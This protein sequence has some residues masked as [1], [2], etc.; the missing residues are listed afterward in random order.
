MSLPLGKGFHA[1][2]DGLHLHAEVQLEGWQYRILNVKEN[3]V[4]KDWTMPLHAST[5]YYGEPANTQFQAVVEA[6]RHLGRRENAHKVFARIKWEPY[7]P[8]HEKKG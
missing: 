6:L 5:S 4:V 7:G 8:G 3:S 1:D 2:L